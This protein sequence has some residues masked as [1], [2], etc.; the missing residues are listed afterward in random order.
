MKLRYN[1]KCP[2]HGGYVCC[3]R[4]HREKQS[5]KWEY[6]RPGVKRIRDE[7]SP[8]GFRYKLSKAEMERVLRMK[9]RDQKGLCAICREEMSDIR[10][11]VPDHQ[12]PK[13]MG[14]G[15]RD[16]RPE[17]IRAVHSRCNLEKGSRRVA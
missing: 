16:D 6:V 9:I 2:I 3:G 17:N 8:D 5:T 15:Q 7:H 13:G 11:V 12:E 1:E 14:G 4:E 10:D